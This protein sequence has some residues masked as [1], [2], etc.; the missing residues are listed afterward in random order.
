MLYVY[1]ML[2]LVA[3][4][5]SLLI[6]V[7]L[8]WPIGLCMN[9]FKMHLQLNLFIALAENFPLDTLLFSS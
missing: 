6:S 9:I 3:Q 8:S 2:Q 7:Q 5:K 4:G 1:S